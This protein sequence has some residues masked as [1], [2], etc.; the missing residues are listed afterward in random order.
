[1]SEDVRLSETVTFSTIG[2]WPTLFVLKFEIG[3]LCLALI[4]QFRFMTAKVLAKVF[5]FA[6]NGDTGAAKLYLS[7]MGYLNNDQSSGNT[8]IQRQ[9][10]YIQING[11]VLS[12]ETIKLLN[13]EQLAGIENILKAV[14]NTAEP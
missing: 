3:D 12:Q 8:L 4:E 13:P 7:A 5:Q 2:P 9:N 6:V 10:N 11:M 1:M 14:A